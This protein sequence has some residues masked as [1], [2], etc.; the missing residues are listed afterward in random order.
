MKAMWLFVLKQNILLQP[1]LTKV[2]ELSQMKNTKTPLG[3]LTSILT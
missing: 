3:L 2:Y 1:T